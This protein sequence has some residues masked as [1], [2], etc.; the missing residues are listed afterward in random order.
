[1]PSS[2][3]ATNGQ[4]TAPID[5]AAVHDAL[6][7]QLTEGYRPT[8]PL[9]MYASDVAIPQ[10]YLQ[11]D[12]EL[13]MIHPMVLS[14]LNYFK[15]GIAQVEFWGGPDPKQPANTAA[16]L[17]ISLDP[18][19]EAFV[20]Q[21]CQKFWDR[22]V[23]VIQGGYEYG[24]IGSEAVYSD[25]ETG[26]L[27]WEKLVQFSPR[28]TFL[29][30]RNSRAIGVRVK[31]IRKDSVQKGE[32]DL[33][34][35]TRDVPAK[36]LW[37]RHEP[38]YN[39]FY[40][41]SQLL[42]AWRPWRRLA[43]KDGI[44]TTADMGMYRYAVP[45]TI[46]GYPDEDLQV[47]ITASLP[48]GPPGTT[49]DSEG[50]PRRY[51]RDMA[52][53]IGQLLK[54]GASIGIPTTQYPPPGGGEKWKVDVPKSTLNIAGIIE[55][56]KHL[57]DQISHGVGVPPELLQGGEWGGSASGRKIPADAFLMRQQRIAD[58]I[59]M[60]F[61]DQILRPLVRWNFGP[62][63]TFNVTIKPL[64][65]TQRMAQGGQTGMPGAAPQ[66]STQNAPNANRQPEFQDPNQ[67][68]A[69]FSLT[70]RPAITNRTL[71][72]AQRIVRKRAA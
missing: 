7:H 40:G 8:L 70:D 1:M 16:G 50:N 34:T 36:G 69:A 47:S 72:L 71:E 18:F 5:P 26:R 27:S 62:Q 44:E 60:L 67:G 2:A 6:V 56:I 3:T 45:P 42:G 63:A 37:Y 11:R 13:M 20:H 59:L 30:T 43:G 29:L 24:W 21:Q 23:P 58:A 15:S 64:L 35:G 48:G 68:W 10:F 49:Q 14:S 9:W 25:D 39:S 52:R 66:Q 4:M 38:R 57:W 28:D 22:G 55:Y 19:V 65:I 46:V 53:Q 33:F 17:P 61:V 41:Q 12:I 54:S 31:N 51:A 32:M